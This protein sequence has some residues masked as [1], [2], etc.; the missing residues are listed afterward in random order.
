MLTAL[1]RRRRRR[2]RQVKWAALAGAQL[3]AAARANKRA[4]KQTSERAS[5]KTNRAKRSHPGEPN[6]RAK[7]K[8]KQP[9]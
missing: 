4:N 7:P 1:F 6:P 3:L 8:L 2:R 9:D 5:A